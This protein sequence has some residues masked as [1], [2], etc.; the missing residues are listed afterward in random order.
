MKRLCVLPLALLGLVSCS[1]PTGLETSQIVGT[2]ST[3]NVVSLR[4]RSN[5]RGYVNFADRGA[6]FVDW[7]QE[8]A[9]LA[10]SF[11]PP[12]LGSNVVA[13]INPTSDEMVMIVPDEEPIF[14]ER[15][16]TE[17]P[18]DLDK[19]LG[20]VATSAPPAAAQGKNRKPVPSRK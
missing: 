8:G 19:R 12:H 9:Q 3:A 10:M 5:G 17:E 7:R 18:P 16:S 13:E 11:T 6:G 4:L 20:I 14:L 15:I 1:T 2:W